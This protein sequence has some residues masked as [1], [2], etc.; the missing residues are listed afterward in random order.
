MIQKLIVMLV[1]VMR[2]RIQERTRNFGHLVHETCPQN[3]VWS[4]FKF[5]KKQMKTEN[6]ESC[7]DVVISYVEAI[8]K[9][10]EDFVHVVTYGAYKPRYLYMCYLISQFWTHVFQTK[11][12]N[13][14]TIWSLPNPYQSE[15]LCLRLT[16]L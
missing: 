16:K 11:L 14:Q 3:C 2:G 1:S 15:A 10:S 7:W 12:R 13:Q 9:I 6:H 8:I 4:V 5:Y